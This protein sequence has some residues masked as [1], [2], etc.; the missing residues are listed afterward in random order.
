MLSGPIAERLG[1]V[2]LVACGLGVAAASLVCNGPSP[3]L[4]QL[5]PVPQHCLALYIGTIASFGV[6]MGLTVAP[7]TNLMVKAATARGS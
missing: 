5:A 1:D 7:T 6:G 4:T 3:L 2:P